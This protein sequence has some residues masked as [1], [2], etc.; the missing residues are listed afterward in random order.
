M[1]VFSDKQGGS[2]GPVR[3][4]QADIHASFGPPSWEVE[5][6]EDAL[7]EPNPGAVLGDGGPPQTEGPAYLAHI[8]RAG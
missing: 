8:C 7:T 2:R 3:I 6:S 4:S 1:L 5:S